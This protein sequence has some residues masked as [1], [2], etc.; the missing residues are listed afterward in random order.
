MGLVK[1]HYFINDYT[2]LTSNCLENHQEVKDIKDCNRIFKEHMDKYK[3]RNDR[4]IKAFQ[5]LKML[6]DTGGKLITP[7]ELTD[8]V[9]NTQF[10]YRVDDYK[11]LPY[12]ETNCRLE[13]YVEKE[14]NMRYSLILKPLLRNIN[15]CHIYVGFTT[16]THNRNLVVL[17]LV[18][19]IC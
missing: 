7:M 9:L 16:M 6:I 15:T 11:T 10:H 14:I 3:K 18:L 8:E 5:T 17:L 2:E 4:F 13:E 12:N 19:W 1:G